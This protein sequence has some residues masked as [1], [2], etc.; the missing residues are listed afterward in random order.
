MNY[1]FSFIKK[2]GPILTEVDLCS[3]LSISY[4]ELVMAL[5]IPDSERYKSGSIPKSDGTLRFIHNPH[6]LIRKIQRRINTRL[7]NPKTEKNKPSSGVISWPSY[8]FGCIPNQ[9]HE[10]SK[11]EFIKDPRDYIACAKVH[12]Q[13]KSIL[14]LDVSNFF[15]NVSADIIKGVFTNLLEYSDEVSEILTNI[16]CKEDSLVQG[17]LTS[18]YLACLAL[19]DVEPDIVKRLK[20]KGLRYTRLIDDITISSKKEDFDFD[21]V[22]D[23]LV[24]ML[25]SKDLP[26]N[27][28]K[29]TRLFASSV[30]LT[31]HGLRVNFKEPRLP[32]DEA[33]RIRACVHN[34][35]K[36]A[37][38]RH[39]R[40]IHPYRKDFN[41]CM[42]RVNKLARLNHKDHLP[43]LKRLQKVIPLPSKLDIERC[44]KMITKLESDY[45][46]GKYKTVWYWRRYN[47]ASQRLIILKRTFQK[48]AFAFRKR[49]KQVPCLYDE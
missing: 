34:V 19:W 44:E 36:L 33:S 40:T 46:L 26:V 2:A 49:L 22:E 21:Y 42:G 3:S 16:C 24:S 12:C 11:N 35:E 6:F 48:S 47:R 37:K 43:L 8:I 18:S 5:S 29:T 39:Y 28:N 13:S 31:V 17:G 25:H 14:K 20:K 15:D 38:E 10:V 4:D 9:I 27:R 45:K 41:R 23:V 7:F 30:P 1:Q 32:S